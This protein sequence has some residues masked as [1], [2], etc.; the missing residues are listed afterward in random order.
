[1]AFAV[2][3]GVAK[4]GSQKSQKFHSSSNSSRNQNSNKFHCNHC[5][6]YGHTMDRCYKLHGYP[7]APKAKTNNYSHVAAHQ[8]STADDNQGSSTSVGSFVQNLNS[9]QYQQ[10]MS[11]LSTHLSSSAK[12][13]T[14]PESSTTNCLTGICFSVSLN[15]LISSQQFWIVDSGATRHIC[16]LA[17]AFISLHVIP[18][19]AVTLPNHSQ[20]LVH[21]VGDVKLHSNLVLKDALFAPQFKFNLIFVSALVTASGLTVRFLPDCFVIQDLSTQRMIGKGDKVQ[22]LYVLRAQCLN[23]ASIAFVNNV[24][25]HVWHNRLGHIS[26]KKLDSLKDQLQCDV[27]GLYKSDPSFVSTLATHRTKFHPRAWVCVFLGYPAGVKGY[28]FYDVESKQVFIS[29]D[30][31][32]HEDIFPFHTITSLAQITDPFPDLVL[33]HSSIQ[34]P[35]LPKLD[36][37]PIPASPAI[38]DVTVDDLPTTDIPAL[39]YSATPLLAGL[40][41]NLLVGSSPSPSVSYPISNYLSYHAL[42]DSDR[43]FALSVSSQVEPQYYHQAVQ[44]HEWRLVMRDELKALEANNT[45]IVTSL[46]PNK[47]TIGCKWVYKIKLKSY[48]S[49][50]R[51]K[52]RLVA[53]GYTQQEGLD[54]VDTF[55]PVAKL[56]TV[57]LR[58]F[59]YADWGSCLDF[60]RSTMGFCIFIGNSLVSW[61]AKK[62]T[63]VSRSSAEA[64]YRALSSTASEIIWL[65]QLL[66]DFQVKVASPALLYCDNQVAIHIAYNPTFHERTKHIEIDCHF[67]REFVTSEVLKLLPIRFQSQLAD[68][69]TKPLPSTQLFSLLFKM[70]V[71][72][73]Y[74]PP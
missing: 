66:Q 22:D 61:K 16:S 17:P 50:E 21:F 36:S 69:F 65:Q 10:L 51:Y 71:K 70:A 40:S 53:K 34:A 35:S 11:M 55:S 62:Q 25:A 44:C 13:S 68:M 6:R 38:S 42:S 54:F 15:P 31:V 29:R 27:T 64:E 47:H 60:R 56:V 4:F 23:S 9:N 18:H 73:I 74:K 30:V 2:K 24:S 33:P 8:V 7:S 72:D 1:M 3:T 28:K 41:L 12:V 5:K 32:F 45:W 67:V 59:S 37:S 57:K 39:E 43:Q 46:P 63:T 58:A 49:L 48:G 26:F 14:A 20:I 19:T 52:A